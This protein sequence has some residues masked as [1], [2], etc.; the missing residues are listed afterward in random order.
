[1]PPSVHQP[2]SD[3]IEIERPGVGDGDRHSGP[4]VSNGTDIRL[5]S[6]SRE[7]D[8]RT[9]VE[10]PETVEPPPN[11]LRMQPYPS[12]TSTNPQTAARVATTDIHK[13]YMG[14]Q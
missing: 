6:E 7:D 13:Y 8:R 9:G 11:R 5:D 3:G 1:M 2:K 12:K 14:R 10:S 4:P